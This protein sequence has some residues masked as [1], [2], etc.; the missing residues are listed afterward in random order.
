MKTIIKFILKQLIPLLRFG[1]LYEIGWHQSFKTG[2][3][4]DKE[5]NPLP[6]VTYGFIDFIKPRLNT[7]HSLL[8][9]GSV[10]STLFFANM[11]QSVHSLEHDKSWFDFISNTA[12]KNAQIEYI[13]YNNSNYVF[14]Q[15]TTKYDLI[16]V[17]GRD[18]VSCI[19]KSIDLLN[20]DGVIILDDSE[21]EEYKEGVDFLLKKGFRSIEF[22]GI[23]PGLFYKK[24]TSI[25]YKNLNTLNI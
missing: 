18:R 21:R 8:E 2:A 25:Y 13:E 5:N 20:N 10:N 22:W 12:S 3:P 24:C 16:L 17:D 6:W 14:P 7:N 1:Y 4:V 15:F 9:F 19:K 23:S 11:I